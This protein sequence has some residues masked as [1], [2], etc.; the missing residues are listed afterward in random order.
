MLVFEAA[1]DAWKTG[2]KAALATV[3]GANGSA[4]R[5]SGA[6]MLVYE[7]GSIVGTIGG[8]ALE[9]RAIRAA[10][11]AMQDGVPTRMT[12]NLTLD[13][14]MCCGGAME[15]FI[16]PL[17][18]RAPIVICG[19]GHVAHALAP[20][21][22][23]LDFDITV[24]DERPDLATPERFERCE[25]HNVDPVAFV[26]ERPADAAEFW[27]VVTHDHRLDQDLI[28]QLLQ[29]PHRWV[30]MIGSRA[31][32][33]RFLRRFRAAGL[34]AALF[35]RL[36]APVGLDIG[37][38][39]PAEIAVSIAAELVRVRRGADDRPPVPLAQTR[40]DQG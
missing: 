36:A 10:L 14:G 7:D 28:E 8:G 29:R 6:R 21:L 40:P 12:V 34:D 3:I 19:A 17:Q 25:V 22:A 26:A 1:H 38:E 2:R 30:G 18:T 11:K 4:P 13:L 39:T 35:D 15:V 16:E 32:V 33:A 37:A 23:T 31:K 20:L 24:V 5:S 9:H 27:L